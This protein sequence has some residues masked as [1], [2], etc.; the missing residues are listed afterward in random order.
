MVNPSQMV[1]VGLRDLDP[2]E[3]TATKELGVRAFTMRDIDELGLRRVM[4]ESI[5]TASAGTVGFHVSMDVDWLDP[6]EAPGVGTP[7]WGGPPREGHLALN[8]CRHGLDD[9]N[10]SH[11]SESG[12]R[13]F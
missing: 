2:A 4:E 9:F 7:S 5:R 11:R 8:G 12:S 13:S 1:L 6:S 3:R 10:G